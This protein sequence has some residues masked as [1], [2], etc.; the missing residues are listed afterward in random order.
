[1][2]EGKLEERTNGRHPTGAA[3]VE[4]NAIQVARLAVWRKLKIASLER[5]KR[6]ADEPKPQALAVDAE[7]AVYHRYFEQLAQSTRWHDRFM[8]DHHRHARARASKGPSAHQRS[9]QPKDQ[10]P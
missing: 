10:T 6:L 7:D 3:K 5:E 9:T 4:Y 2:D 1:V 8:R